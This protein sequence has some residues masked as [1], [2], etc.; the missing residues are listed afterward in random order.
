MWLKWPPSRGTTTLLQSLRS[1]SRCHH[2]AV[3]EMNHYTSAST[4]PCT[5]H[6]AKRRKKNPISKEKYENHW[7]QRGHQEDY[8]STLSQKTTMEWSEEIDMDEE[9]ADARWSDTNTTTRAFNPGRSRVVER[10]PTCNSETQG[11]DPIGVKGRGWRCNQEGHSGQAQ[12]HIRKVSCAAFDSVCKRGDKR[13][14]VRIDKDDMSDT[15]NHR[16]LHKE[17]FDHP[18]RPTMIKKLLPC[19]ECSYMT[20]YLPRQK[21]K[22]SLHKHCRG[23]HRGDPGRQQQQ[24]PTE[25]IAGDVVRR[26]SEGRMFDHVKV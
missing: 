23:Y 2:Q 21:A 3:E 17:E 1:P 20:D 15:Y 7:K 22:R 10:S 12:A 14:K 4:Y 25:R 16:E 11:G 9:A 8:Q 26:N 13:N 18:A 5:Q 24:A 6:S 19:K